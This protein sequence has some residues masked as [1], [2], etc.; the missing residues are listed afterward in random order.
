MSRGVAPAM[1]GLEKPVK[2]N[3][4]W[5]HDST[6]IP[7]WS[8]HSDP[9]TRRYALGEETIGEVLDSLGPAAPSVLLISP[10]QRRKRGLTRLYK[11]IRRY[12]RHPGVE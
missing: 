2:S 5:S 7:I 4:G 11:N 8:N 10:E 6:D 12:A 9:V 3:L 1:R